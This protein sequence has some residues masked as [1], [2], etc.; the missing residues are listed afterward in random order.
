MTQI[1]QCGNSAALVDYLYDE[2]GPAERAAIAAHMAICRACAAE[3]SGLRA[4]R[5]ELAAW[6]PPEMPLGFR[7]V[8]EMPPARVIREEDPPAAI[9]RQW[10]RRPVPAWAQAAAAVV[11][12]GAGL[13]LG[14][15]RAT[16]TPGTAAAG[17]SA[18]TASA[19]SSTAVSASD[20]TALEQRLRAELTQNRSVPV[21]GPQNRA[22]AQLLQQVRALIQESEQRQQRELALRTAEVVRD[23]D[24]QRRGDLTR[25]ERTFG[26]MEGTTG[27]QVEQQRQVLDYLMKVSQ[28]QP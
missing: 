4:A 6:T 14:A 13:T 5:V 2:C 24:A 20:L 11:L 23:F 22:D 15:L 17:R 21:S 25:I 3:A 19:A 10:W 9:P 16:S 7:V 26:Q 1:F 12:F 28:R 27:V 8:H 18:L